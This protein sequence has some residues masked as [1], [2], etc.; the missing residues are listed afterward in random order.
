MMFIKLEKNNVNLIFIKNN[1]NNIQDYYVK[2]RCY[3]EKT[4]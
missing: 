2:S 1:Q 4:K 3:N